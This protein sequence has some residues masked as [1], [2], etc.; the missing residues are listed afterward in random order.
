MAVIKKEQIKEKLSDF[1]S[2]QRFND[3]SKVPPR[4]PEQN[5]KLQKKLPRVVGA[6][7]LKLTIH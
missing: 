5:S 3:E 7:I 6:G 4:Q 1:R 2:Q